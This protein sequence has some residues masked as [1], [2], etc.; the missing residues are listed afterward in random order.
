MRKLNKKEQN[1]ILNLSKKFIGIHSRIV[2][3]EKQIQN[4]EKESSSLI[5]ELE[6]CRETEREF[7]RKMENK[8]GEGQIDPIQMSWKTKEEIAK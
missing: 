8:Y 1:E 4:L 6:I 5:S 2:D 7:Y 3:V